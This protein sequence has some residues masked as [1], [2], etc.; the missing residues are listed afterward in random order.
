MKLICEREKCTA[1]AACVQVCPKECIILQENT[2]GFLYPYIDENY[3][4]NC[5][6][7]KRVCHIQTKHH[8]LLCSVNFKKNFFYI[9]GGAGDKGIRTQSILEELGISNRLVE[10][11]SEI[12]IDSSIDY[13]GV[14]DK[15]HRF[16]EESIE[17][18]CKNLKDFY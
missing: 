7:C 14:D 2:D 12:D 17:Y 9:S 11:I 13:I 16:R 10:D 4:V 5:G 6:L 8:G 18:L 3:C 1:C 15:L